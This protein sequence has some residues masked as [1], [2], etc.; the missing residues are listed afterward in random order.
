MNR[1][2]V[3][4]LERKVGTFQTQLEKRAAISSLGWKIGWKQWR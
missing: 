4:A 3:N 1:E 2:R